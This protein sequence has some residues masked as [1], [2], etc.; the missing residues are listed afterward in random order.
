MPRS[1]AGWLGS[2]ARVLHQFVHCASPHTRTRR[3]RLYQWLDQLVGLCIRHLRPR[4]S[5]GLPSWWRGVAPVSH[6]G[7]SRCWL[8]RRLGS[9]QARVCQFGMYYPNPGTSI[10]ESSVSMAHAFFVEAWGTAV[11]MFV[12]LALT[13]TKNGMLGPHK[14]LAPFFIGFTVACLISVCVCSVP[15]V[16]DQCLA[17]TSPVCVACSRVQIRTTHPSRLEPSS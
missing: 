15:C 2:C 7:T 11:L 3:C 9:E 5:G 17:S 4:R 14:E 6:D 1:S 8:T 10:P 13:N 16:A 12:I